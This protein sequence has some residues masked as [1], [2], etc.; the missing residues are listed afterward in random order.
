MRKALL[1]SGF[2]LIIFLGAFL[3]IRNIYHPKTI[4]RQAIKESELAEGGYI[5]CKRERVTGF[6]FSVIKNEKGEKVQEYCNIIGPSPFNDFDFRHNFVMA[7]NTYIFY[8]EAKN[9]VYSEVTK[10]EEIEYTVTGWDILYP[11]K[12]S[13]FVIIDMF[14]PKK[15][16]VEADVR[17]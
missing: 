5:L 4:I 6:H 17:N 3:Y 15:Y 10:Q 11:V 12:H 13:D 16:I 14:Y 9:M 1:V 7:D 8:V 2:I